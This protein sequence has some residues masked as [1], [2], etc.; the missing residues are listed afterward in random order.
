MTG[1]G[2]GKFNHKGEKLYDQN[3]KFIG[4]A[5]CDDAV[6]IGKR[7]SYFPLPFY[8]NSFTKGY[9]QFGSRRSGGKR[10]HAGA[11]LYAP[12]GTNV[13]SITSGEVLRVSKFYRGSSAIE[14]DHYSYIG[15]YTEI[16]PIPGLKTGVRVNPGQKIG[17]I[18]DLKLS[19]SMLHFEMYSGSAIGPLTN[20]AN[21]PYMRRSDLLNP[22]NFLLNLKIK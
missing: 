10:T 7:P 14:I 1:Y 12:V 21:L 8:T 3:G 11:D 2:I 18:M 9:A 20:T 16:D 17:T 19:N 15:R 6:I 4:I 22:T 13:N 5:S